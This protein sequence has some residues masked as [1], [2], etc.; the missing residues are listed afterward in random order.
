MKNLTFKLSIVVMYVL[1]S[2]K[3]SFAQGNISGYVTDENSNLKIE[4]AAISL[5]NEYNFYQ[6]Q[7]D[8]EGY[9][10]ISNIESGKYKMT[11][12][13]QGK[14][15]EI[16]NVIVNNNNINM[17]IAGNFTNI[18]GTGE[19]FVVIIHKSLF[20]VDM[21]DVKPIDHEVIKHGPIRTIEKAVTTTSTTV[22]TPK[23]LSIKGARPGTAVYYIDGMRT[24][25]NL[26]IPMSAIQDI[27]VYS[28]AVPAKYGDS[29]S[30]VIAVTTKGYF[31][32]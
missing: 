19:D 13:F 24:Y 15:Q 27:E 20:R 32:Y 30:G 29:T 6:A 26:N 11:I 18:I 1:F 3:V 17:S 14:K 9:Y 16:E 31:D 4:F 8:F 7:S 5:E 12:Y 22:E 21:P 2:T 10:S 28:G 23:G 25:G